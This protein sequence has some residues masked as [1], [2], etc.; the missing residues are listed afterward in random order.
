MTTEFY[1]EG[2][3]PAFPW[4]VGG[5]ANVVRRPASRVRTSQRAGGIVLAALLALV[6]LPASAHD[7][8]M[9][10]EGGAPLGASAAF[11]PQG[12]LWMVDAKDGHVWLRRSDDLG[13][14][15]AAP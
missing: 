6:A 3:S 1:S 8:A 7:A 9:S 4:P 15:F 14:H 13:R 5:G 2:A 12:H 10:K 11:D